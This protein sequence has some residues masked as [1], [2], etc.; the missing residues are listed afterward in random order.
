MMLIDEKMIK[1]IIILLMKIKY[2]YRL[3]KRKKHRNKKRTN[4]WLFGEWFGERCCDNCL[5]LANFVSRLN[6]NL[7]LFWIANN[8]CD[9][10]LLDNTITVVE[11]DSEKAN[12]LIKEAEVIIVNQGL[13]DVINDLAYVP[14]N[15]LIVNLWHGMPW[16]KILFDADDKSIIYMIKK[17][18]YKIFNIC[19][20]TIS[21]SKENSN[22]IENAFLI[23]KNKII[24]SGYPRN[25]IFYNVNNI[26]HCRNKLNGFINVDDK[27]VISYLP[28]FRSNNRLFDIKSLLVNKEFNDYL[29]NNNVII[30]QK[31]HFADNSENNDAISNFIYNVDEQI[32]TQ[33]LLCAS[34][35]LITDYSS[36]FFDFLLL[37]RPIIHFLYDYDNYIN[38]DR[39]LY[40]SK[41]DVCCGDCVYNSNELINSIINNI[42]C[43]N[44]D[45]ELRLLR[46]NT[47]MNYSSNKACKIIY[48]RIIQDLKHYDKK[49]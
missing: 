18:F 2:Y 8:N 36:C 40:Y 22:I 38:N 19:D 24:E 17:I 12:Q 26:H 48:Q 30:V 9:T 27:I 14:N 46:K 39:G 37:N 28:T 44:K 31:K 45:R 4:I 32:T 1:K 13:C 20:L 49:V 16:K 25:E 41:E 11:K 42:N 23:N 34:D 6:T 35:I 7:S 15:S 5:Y 10:S 29:L 21:T 33:E 3:I 43:I 47:F